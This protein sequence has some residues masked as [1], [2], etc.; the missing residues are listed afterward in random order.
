M[1]FKARDREILNFVQNYGSITINICAKLFF[2][3]ANNCKDLARKRL[4]ILYDSNYLKKYQ[5][6]INTEAIYYINK[7]LKPHA[8]KLLD[9]YAE[10]STMGKV[11]KFKKEYKV[12]CKNKTR[13]LDAFIELEVEDEEYITIYPIIIEIDY[14]HVTSWEKARDIYESNYFQTQYD[15]VFPTLIIVQRNQ[16][17]NKFNTSLFNYKYIN[18]NL[19]NLKEVFL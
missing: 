14:S 3:D 17:Q 8:L 11:I 9:V 13:K 7:P 15:G 1:Y 12:E 6:H 16:W 19:D 4:R 10:L 18:W 2:K 5:E